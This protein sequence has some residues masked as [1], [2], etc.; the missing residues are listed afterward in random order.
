M[1]D[2]LTSN[3]LP[4]PLL[5]SGRPGTSRS[6]GSALKRVV[7]DALDLD[8]RH[9]VVVQKLACAEPGCPSVE[10]VIAVLCADAPPRRWTVHQPLA[11]LTHDTVRAA[12]LRHSEEGDIR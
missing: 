10:T 7:R 3:Q 4:R 8:E 2:T 1:E 5:P 9:T 11:E 6:H 12:V